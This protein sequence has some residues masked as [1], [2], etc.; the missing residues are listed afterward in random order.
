MAGWYRENE[1]GGRRK[2][3]ERDNDGDWRHAP[4]FR[5]A[6]CPRVVLN[7]IAFSG[8]VLISLV[9]QFPQNL[10]SPLIFFFHLLFLDVVVASTLPICLFVPV[11][12]PFET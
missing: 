3:C 11:L 12:L 2:G 6:S 7:L 8:Q 9:V 4:L 1:G 10:S 5:T